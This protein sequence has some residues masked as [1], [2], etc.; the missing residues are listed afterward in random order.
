MFFILSKIIGFIIYPIHFILILTITYLL[1]IKIKILKTFSRFILLLISICLVFGGSD[2]FSNYFLWKLEQTIPLQLPEKV[3]GII[4]LGGSFHQI[5]TAIEVNQVSLN[6]TAERAIEALYLLNE[7]PNSKLIFVASSGSLN[8]YDPSEAKL[9]RSFF[10]KFKINK[11]RINIEPLANNT[12]Q[13]SVIIS[14]YISQ[15]GGNWVLVTSASHMP[16]AVNLFQSR[17]LYE[18]VIYTYPTG[19][20]VDD[21][22][23]SLGYHL[24]NLGI[25]SKLIHEYI[26]LLAYRLT[27][28]TKKFWPNVE[29]LPINKTNL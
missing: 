29:N 12:F 25:Y 22:T 16:R 15:V 8:S 20:S 10:K 18:A 2:Y 6:E 28:R 26:G 19:Y 27:G 9:A 1:L 3:E 5:K 13:E 21:P 17:G 23:F 24:G 7:H 11:N 14:E 4:L